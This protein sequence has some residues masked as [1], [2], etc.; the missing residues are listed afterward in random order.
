MKGSRSVELP[1]KA[2]SLLLSCLLYAAGFLGVHVWMQSSGESSAPAFSVNSVHLSFTQVEL[3]AAVETPPP[4]PQPEPEPEPPEEVDVVL[5]ERV[6]KP[7]EPEPELEPEPEVE[8]AK[9]A[10]TPPPP[11][12]VKPA[13]SGDLEI[14]W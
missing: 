3:Q 6:E 13:F 10:L 2:F 8:P 14:E 11:R 4:E 12:V 7:P 1:W 5:E 9:E